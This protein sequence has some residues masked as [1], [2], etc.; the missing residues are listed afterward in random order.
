MQQNIIEILDAEI[1]AV[2][3][4]QRPI[5][6]QLTK[7]ED[8]I[9]K[10]YSNLKLDGEYLLSYGEVEHQPVQVERN[11]K[12]L[13]ISG[14]EETV[15][16]E[17]NAFL[18]KDNTTL[19][20]ALKSRIKRNSLATK[21]FFIV[22]PPGTGKTKVITKIL[23]KAIQDGKKVLI[24]SPTN[25]AIENVFER[26][27]FQKLNLKDGE[28]LLTV[29]TENRDLDY[30][31]PKEI[32]S[33]KIQS[34]QDE[35]DVLNM[36]Y[37]EIISQKR[38]MQPILNSLNS[39]DESLGIK[40]ANFKAELSEKNSS[41]NKLLAS[42]KALENRIKTL[43]GNSLIQS[44]A[45]MFLSDKIEELYKDLSLIDQKIASCKKDITSLD[46]K[47]Q[48]QNSKKLSDSMK[49]KDIS[50]KMGK[51]NEVKTKLEN[52][53]KRLKKEVSVVKSNNLFNGA[54]LVGATLMGT[55]LNQKIQHAEFDMVIVDE[56][57]MGSIATLVV[58]SQA[59]KV[60]KYKKT[61][62]RKS[63]FFTDSQNEAI[64]LALDNQL[65]FVGD[66]KQ[67]SPIAKTEEMKKSVFEMYGVEKI[68]DG[69][70]VDNTVFLDINFR[71]HPNITN[72]ASSL[73]YGGLLH[74]GKD[75]NGKNSLFIRR[76]KSNMTPSDGSY[77]NSGNISIV[78]EQVSLALSKG[79]RNIGVITPYRQ[80]A[81]FLTRS[82]KSLKEEYP[83]AD[84]QA[85]T[86]HKF[87]GKEKEIIIF[88]LTFSPT[89]KDD[90]LPVT[91]DGDI[92]SQTAKL[93]N[94]AMTRAESFFILVGNIDGILAI[95]NTQ[96]VLLKWIKE[97]SEI[98]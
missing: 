19:F 68:F 96:S 8:G 38:N 71:N 5:N 32:S 44:I 65:V 78:R 76:S 41:L 21:P 9:Y 94:V 70:P 62:Y 50:L 59:L 10:C 28:V 67:L 56:A 91:Y 53:L 47:L 43:K 58:A 31:S 97:I 69:E 34:L 29:K 24:A 23:E 54:K 39:K 16:K 88:D 87:Q 25:M 15:L 52:E 81:K 80:Q 85:G 92:N 86:V 74:A 7:D 33:R 36:A 12:T 48:K 63:K 84:I 61:R 98:N 20:N 37:D 79:R 93:L 77:V 40:I 89:K 95:E 18:T 17:I 22:G 66:P 27:D 45:K 6:I 26:I 72:L 30:L 1:R 55:A 11:G 75:S 49:I 73:F 57:S 64:R 46:S 42:K 60:Q 2:E 82:L 83:D 90:V 4:S 51:I 35:I 13:L 14:I 3:K